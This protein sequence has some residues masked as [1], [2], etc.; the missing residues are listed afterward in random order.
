MTE[1][2]FI[3]GTLAPGRDNAW[4]MET[5]DGHWQSATTKGF[6]KTL[7]WGADLGFPG[8]TPDPNGEQV[9]GW[10]FSSSQLQHHWQGLD[11]FEGEQY[12][13]VLINVTLEN[14][15]TAQ[16]FVYSIVETSNQLNG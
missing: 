14:G 10:L 12:Q 4:V 6:L 1:H 13:R 15:K 7:G 5:I 8:L 11:E 2:L 16:A 3:Y 9:S